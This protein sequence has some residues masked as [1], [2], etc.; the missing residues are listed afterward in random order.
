MKEFVTSFVRSAQRNQS[1]DSAL[2]S[3]TNEVIECLPDW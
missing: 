2:H 3:E 1:V